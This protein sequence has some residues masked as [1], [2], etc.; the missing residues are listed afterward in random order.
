MRAW[1][2]GQSV[3]AASH[4]DVTA[5]IV[6]HGD[7]EIERLRARCATLETALRKI[8]DNTADEQPPYR[9]LGASG[10]VC[11][12]ARAA[13]H[14]DPKCKRCGV[15]VTNPMLEWCTTC[16]VDAHGPNP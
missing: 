12:I 11:D 5:Q 6:A 1:A 10:P 13:L 4:K 16:F 14:G 9:G 2:L 3:S 15:R 8:A 7:T